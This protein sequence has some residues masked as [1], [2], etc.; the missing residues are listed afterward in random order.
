MLLKNYKLWIHIHLC[1]HIVFQHNVIICLTPTL[2]ELNEAWFLG[3]K[4]S[5]LPST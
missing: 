1:R 4:S 5:P 3:L 2:K